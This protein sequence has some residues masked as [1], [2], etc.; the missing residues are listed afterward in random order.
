[1]YNIQFQR[2]IEKSKEQRTLK[3]GPKFMKRNCILVIKR[4]RKIT[5]AF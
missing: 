4:L 1:M 5:L 3:S 2:T